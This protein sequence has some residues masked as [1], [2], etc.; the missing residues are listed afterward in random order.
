MKIYLPDIEEWTSQDF[1]RWCELQGFGFQICEDLKAK[2]IDG[3]AFLA[4]PLEF[5]D[6]F[7]IYKEY[8]FY[9]QF[10]LKFIEKAHLEIKK[11]QEMIPPPS[12]DEKFPA[13]E[14]PENS[15]DV[16]SFFNLKITPP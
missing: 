6:F 12:L 1:C 4:I 15:K 16:S 11:Q 5:D 14:I 3:D 8:K 7:D 9:S 10:K 13:R 2:K